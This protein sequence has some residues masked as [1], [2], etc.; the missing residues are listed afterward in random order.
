MAILGSAALCLWSFDVCKED[1]PGARV[2]AD[3]LRDPTKTRS[4]VERALLP[5]LGAINGSEGV[6]LEV[7]NERIADGKQGATLLFH[8]AQELATA[9]LPSGGG[10]AAVGID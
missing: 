5:M 4:Y 1:V 10:R 3:L 6:V 7:I 9:I 2:H 8:F